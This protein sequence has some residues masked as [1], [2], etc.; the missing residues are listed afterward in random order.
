MIKEQVI[1]SNGCR[2]IGQIMKDL[3]DNVM[4]NKVTTGCGMTSVVLKNE[5]KYV[6]AVPFVSLIKNMEK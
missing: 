3:P 1:E 4:F 6:L 2:Y 5:L